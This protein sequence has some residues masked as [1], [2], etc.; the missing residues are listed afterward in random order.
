MPDLQNYYSSLQ[1]VDIGKS[2]E[3][4]A[5]TFFAGRESA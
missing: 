4:I 1:E 2:K 3:L 5:P